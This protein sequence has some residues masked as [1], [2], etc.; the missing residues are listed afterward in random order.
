M[1]GG[2]GAGYKFLFF[3]FNFVY[4]F[5]FSFCF[6]E[7]NSGFEVSDR[8]EETSTDDI[9]NRQNKTDIRA[10]Y[11]HPLNLHY[12]SLFSTL[13]VSWVEN[14]PYHTKKG[15]SRIFFLKVRNA[16]WV[17]KYTGSK[18]KKKKKKIM[19]WSSVCQT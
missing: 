12:T 19:S 7:T 9:E 5:H 4:A 3:F 6:W 13:Y 15:R 1:G 14:Y 8:R 2:K 18:K 16:S 11:P 10:F 17:E